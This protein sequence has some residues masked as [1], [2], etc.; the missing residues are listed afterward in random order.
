M[1]RPTKLTK[2]I[3]D[4][5]VAAIRC[6]NY[7]AT[8][9]RSAGIG[10]RTYYTWLKRGESVAKADA[11]FRQ[12]RQ[13]IKKA[14]GEAEVHAVALVRQAM[15]DDWKAA[16]T[17]LERRFPERWRRREAV[18]VSGAETVAL[19]IDLKNDAKASQLAHELLALLPVRREAQR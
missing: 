13:A 12:F 3:A 17:W 19:E 18:E 2:A 9:A 4:Q 5:I 1:A 7:A 14:E 15:P 6:G 16:M 8:A 11:P 10:E